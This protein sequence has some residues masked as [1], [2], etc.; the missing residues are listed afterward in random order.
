MARTLDLGAAREDRAQATIKVGDVSYVAH[1]VPLEVLLAITGEQVTP[2]QF[3]DAAKAVLGD[4]WDEFQAKHNP[5]LPDIKA[6]VRF[7]MGLD[8]H[9]EG[10]ASDAS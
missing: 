3:V 10:Q 6:I 1:E 4:Q 9:P 8:D 7:G 2:A 5:S